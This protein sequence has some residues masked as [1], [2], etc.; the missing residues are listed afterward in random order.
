VRLNAYLE[1]AGRVATV[2]WLGLL[3]SLVIGVD[4]ESLVEKVINSGRPVESAVV[5]AVVLPAIVFLLARSPLSAA[6]WRLHRELWRRD[7]ETP[8]GSADAVDA[9]AT[10]ESSPRR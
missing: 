8:R 5:L 3:V 7:V 6:R 1:L 2:L 9:S 4:W 10:R